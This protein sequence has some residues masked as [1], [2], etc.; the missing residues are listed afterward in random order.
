MKTGKIFAIALVVGW[1]AGVPCLL[2]AEPAPEAVLQAAAQGL[3]PYLS[4]IPAEALEQ[5]GFA[6]G[7]ALPTATLG[8]PFLLYTLTPAALDQ[9]QEGMTVASLVTPTSM[10][11]FPVLVGGQPRAILVV[12]KL[13]DKWQA[14]SLGYAGLA[15]ELGAI[16]R[17]WNA[18][19]G[20]QPLLIAVFQAKQYLFT[21]P[22][23]D[24]YNLTPLVVK[25]AAAADPLNAAAVFGSDYATLG[26]AAGVIGQLKPAVQNALKGSN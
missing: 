2:A 15:Q 18:A 12:D 23:K 16:S 6:S 17:L 7:D 4:K 24:A 25:K 21:V 8:T 9:Y 13:A 19:Q 26:T 5:Y 14:V 20:Y 10:W 11:Y 22:E 1:M 3:Q